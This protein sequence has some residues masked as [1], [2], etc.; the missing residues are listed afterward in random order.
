MFVRVF[1]FV[2][3][4]VMGGHKSRNVTCTFARDEMNTLVT[5][6]TQLMTESGLDET[7]W[8]SGSVLL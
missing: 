5:M 4:Q 3:R 2:R 1:L 7:G 6:H 8:F